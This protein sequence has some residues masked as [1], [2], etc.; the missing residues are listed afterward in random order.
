MILLAIFIVGGLL[1]IVYAANRCLMRTNWYHN[2]FVFAKDAR[3]LQGNPNFEI[4]LDIVNVGSNPARFSFFYENVNGLNLSYGTQSLDLD[5]AVLKEHK[6][7]LKSGCY[8]LLPI[9]PFSSISAYLENTLNLYIKYAN[10]SPTNIKNKE[11]LSKARLLCKYP[12]LF[13]PTSLRYLLKDS[14]P[15]NLL[16]VSEQQMQHV[17]LVQD[18]KRWLKCWKEEFRIIK[19][20]DPLSGELLEAREKS[21][22]LFSELI[23]YVL[24]NDWKPVIISPPFSKELSELFTPR[25]KEVYV[26]SFIREFDGYKI[27]YLDYIY[28]ET[29][30]DSSLYVNALFMNLKG[31]KL[32]TLDVLQK[33][34]FT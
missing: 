25:M 23:E 9:V 4:Q 31:R 6:G 33:L 28:D 7:Y 1:L 24:M 19:L 32:F 2:L 22:K 29:F 11:L 30:S 8:V 10:F 27:P 15:N 16:E 12:L 21:I 26:D 20:G 5:L 34:S 17:E 18:A 13:S 14:Y 3:F